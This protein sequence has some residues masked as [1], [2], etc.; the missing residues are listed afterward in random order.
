MYICVCNAISTSDIEANPSLIYKCGTK[1]GKCIPYIAKGL[2]PGTEQPYE[3]AADLLN[4]T[5]DTA[6]TNTNPQ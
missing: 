4:A 1:C 5:N 6:P 3:L 2:Y